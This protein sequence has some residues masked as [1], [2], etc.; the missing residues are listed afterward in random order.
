MSLEIVLQKGVP[1]GDWKFLLNKLSYSFQSPIIL[2]DDFNKWRNCFSKWRLSSKS[3]T[4]SDIRLELESSKIELFGGEK[5]FIHK[6][7]WIFGSVLIVCVHFESCQSV[8]K[9]SRN[10][11]QISWIFHAQVWNFTKTRKLVTSVSV[12]IVIFTSTSVTNC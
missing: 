1:E 2:T 3:S 10:L 11:F 5:V 6:K 8:K 4:E 12:I 7:V 9:A